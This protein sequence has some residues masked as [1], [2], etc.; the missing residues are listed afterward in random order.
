M[1]SNIFAG[2]YYVANPAYT[3]FSVRKIRLDISVTHFVGLAR[4]NL[5]DTSLH[6]PG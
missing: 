2:T 6:A 1:P 3:Q 4:C 5:L